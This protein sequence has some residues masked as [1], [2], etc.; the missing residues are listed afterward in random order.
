ML[1][2]VFQ[3]QRNIKSFLRFY[4]NGKLFQYTCLPNGISSAPRIFTKLLKPVY[5]SLRVLGHVNVGYIDDSL[6]L[7]E[8]IEECNKN[9]NDTIE[10]MSKLGFVIHEDK[11]VFQP[12]KQIIFLGN[13]IDSE[14]MIITLTADK[15]QNLVKECKWLLQRNLAKIRDVAKVIGLIVSSFSAVEF[16]KLFY[17]NLEKEKIIALKNSK[18]DFEQS[19]LISNQMKGDLE[20]WVANVS[21]ELRHISHGSPQIV[22]QT[23]ASL[24]GWGGILSDNEIGGRWTDEES[25]NH[26]NY[27]EI[28]AIYY[29]LK[30]FLHLIINKHVKVLTDNTTAVAYISN[31]GGTKSIDCNTI[32]RQIWLFCKDNDIWLTCTHIAGKENLADKKSREFDDKLEWKLKRSVFDQLCTLWQRPDIDLFASRLNFQLENY[33]SWK[34]D[35]LSAFIDAFSINWSYFQFVYLFPPFSLLSRCIFKIR[36]DG[37]RGVVIAP[38]WQTQTWFPRLMQLLTDNP[39][40]LPKNKK[41]LNLP[42]DPQS[43][44]PLHKKMKLI[45][46]LVSGVA[47]ENEDFLKKQPTYSCRLGNQVQRNSTKCISGNGSNIEGNLGYSSLNL[48]RGALSSLGLTIDSIPVGRHAMVIR[49]MK[50]IFNLRPPRPRYESTWDVSKVLQFLR[51]LSPVKYLKLKDLTLKLT[52]LIAL[53]NAARAQSI[54]FMNVNHVHKVKGEF[55]FVLNELVKQSRPGYKEPTVNIKAYPP[56]RRLCVYTV[57]KEYVFRTK[58]FRGKHEP[59]L[60]SYVKPHQ[61]VSRDTISRWIKVVMAKANIDTTIFKA[62][63][64]R[65]ASVS[66]A[67]M[68]AVPISQA[69]L[70]RKQREHRSGRSTQKHRRVKEKDRLYRQNIKS[71]NDQV[72]HDQQIK[73]LSTEPTTEEN[74]STAL[75]TWTPA[76]RRKAISRINRKLL[77]VGTSLQRHNLDFGFP[78]ERHFYG[79]C[80]GKGPS[81]G[82]GAVVKSVV[83]RAVLVEQVVINNARDLYDFSKKLEIDSDDHIHYKRSLF[84]VENVQRDRPNRIIAK[85]LVGTRKLQ[86]VRTVTPM[87]IETRNVTCFCQGCT[88][89]NG[90]CGNSDYVEKWEEQHLDGRNQ[91]Q[92][93]RGR[94][95]GVGRGQGRRGRGQGQGRSGQGV[96]GQGKGRRGRGQGGKGRGRGIRQ[97]GRG[98]GAYLQGEVLELRDAESNQ[99]HYEESIGIE[100]EESISN[101]ERD[102]YLGM[103]NNTYVDEWVEQTL[104]NDLRKLNQKSKSKKQKVGKRKVTLTHMETALNHETVE[105][106]EECQNK[107]THDTKIIETHEEP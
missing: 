62:H 78:I 92:G 50:G 16:G 20:W 36:E 17:R 73:L 102:C 45:A 39:I 37:A 26:I 46:C 89:L 58:L 96:R 7:G 11:S 52:M 24:L 30:S 69:L 66:K 94:G 67:K 19:M 107:E 15:K 32:S 57:Y 75:E 14:N 51:S 34:P 77:D 43:V 61:P 27:L 60:L 8:T 28:L 55:I 54:H 12:S 41:I 2:I 63:S 21:T 76:A 98:R 6:L 3:L 87:T 22:I 84:L 93:R 99:S 80:H 18:G 49:Y 90:E 97:G 103:E 101:E 35:P 59:L 71:D 56:D 9:V 40:V 44:H 29:T 72:S 4:W 100:N 64:V 85:T 53:T 47:S 86:C 31:M 33:C 104:T 5:S 82:A 83:R 1:I 74:L 23:D 13:I 95:Q 25:K 105:T 70:A 88:S 42:H 106:H 79:S 48:A 65:S 10:L 91:G 81:E 38:F 68:N